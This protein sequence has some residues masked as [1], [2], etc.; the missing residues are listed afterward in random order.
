MGQ[1]HECH[2]PL[3]AAL[4]GRDADG[5]FLDQP[6]LEEESHDDLRQRDDQGMQNGPED[7]SDGE[8]L[9]GLC[10]EME[11]IMNDTIG[12]AIPANGDESDDGDESHGP[13]LGPQLVVDASGSG[14]HERASPGAEGPSDPAVPTP[15]TAARSI[16][17]RTPMQRLQEVL[18]GK[19]PLPPGYHVYFNAAAESWYAK[20]RCADGKLRWIRGSSASV[21]RCGEEAAIWHAY[22]SAISQ[23]RLDGF[24][25]L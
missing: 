6:N 23:R 8:F 5:L 10:A 13:D 3:V 14:S 24:T 25:D 19:H 17:F 21:A 4:L 9:S 16:R 12:N 20:S 18:Q 7:E 22:H 2:D 11:S 15:E 1:P